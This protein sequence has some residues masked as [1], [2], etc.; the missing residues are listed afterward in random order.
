MALLFVFLRQLR[1]HDGTT[2]FDGCDN[3]EA[4]IAA[5][6]THSTDGTTRLFEPDVPRPRGGTSTEEDTFLALHQRLWETGR[7]AHHAIDDAVEQQLHLPWDIAPI[8][9]RSHNDGIGLL[10]HLQYSLGV[11]LTKYTLT[12]S[13]TGHTTDAGLD[14]QVVGKNCLHLI[15]S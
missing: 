15:T 8:A 13:A 6:F 12:F 7:V 3:L 5:D 14:V 4:R 1:M 11:I 10:H 2:S 9:G